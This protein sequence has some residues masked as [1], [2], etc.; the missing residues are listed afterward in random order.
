MTQRVIAA[1][2]ACGLIALTNAS[3]LPIP[4]AMGAKSS[5]HRYSVPSVTLTD[6]YGRQV[7][8][9]R[10]LTGSQPVLVQFFF[11][12]CTT[13]CGVRSAQL[14]AIAPKLAAAGVRIDIYSISIDPENDTPSRLLAYSREFGTPPPNWHLLTGPEPDVKRVQAAFDASDPSAD[15]MMHRPLTFI[16]GG[17]GR[18]WVRLDGLTSAHELLAQIEK[19]VAAA[20]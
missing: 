18:P 19:T 14:C 5:L 1:I 4:D 17:K 7:R 16:C 9:D 12:T 13:I 20:D 2:L 10:A 8:L 15:R 6:Q 3:A 11:A